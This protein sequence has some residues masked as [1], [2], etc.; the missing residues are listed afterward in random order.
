MARRRL[1]SLEKAELITLV[2]DMM[3]L[4]VDNKLFVRSALVDAED[5]E[6][7]KYKK[8]I[9]H[10][11]SYNERGTKDWDL[12]E[13]GRIIRYLE[14]ATD[15]PMIRADVYVHTVVQGHRITDELGD[16]DEKY[17]LSMEDFYEDAAKWV[18]AAEKQG[19]DISLLK[20][21]LHE[22][23]LKAQG[24]GWGYCDE[25]SSLWSEYFGDNDAE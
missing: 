18:L 21:S 10:A 16:I 12:K 11:L 24:I 5:I 15:D 13:A 8:K 3:E 23:M 17:Y 20:E 22:V 9:S 4:S 6:V 14:K 7:D 25:L 1:N 2:K 19:H